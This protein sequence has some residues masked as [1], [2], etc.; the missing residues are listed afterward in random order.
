MV[1]SEPIIPSGD[2]NDIAGKSSDGSIQIAKQ[3]QSAAF[4]P[5][6]SARDITNLAKVTKVAVEKR[7]VVLA[8]GRKHAKKHR[9]S[10][11]HIYHLTARTH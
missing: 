8:A 1:D 11:S 2:I 3:I 9:P 5:K 4:T 10:V 7:N 6:R